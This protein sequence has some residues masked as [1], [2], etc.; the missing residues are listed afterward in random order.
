MRIIF[1]DFKG[2]FHPNSA[3]ARFQPLQP[4][5]REVNRLWL[6]R[7]AWILADLI[8]KQPDV[9]IVV[10]SNW[11]YLATGVE[12]QSFLGPLAPRY[13]GSTKGSRERWDSIAMTVEQNRLRNYLILDALPTA[14]PANVNQLLV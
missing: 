13:V 9:G 11:R 3:I 12:L 1:T 8:E 6:F 2:I 14:Y 5:Q 7:W 10:H 4:L